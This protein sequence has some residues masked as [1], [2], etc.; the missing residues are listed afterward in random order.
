M[1]WGLS[2]MSLICPATV[3]LRFRR[4]TGMR[5]L[6]VEWT[7]ICSSVWIS[8]RAPWTFHS[9]GWAGWPCLVTRSLR[10]TCLPPTSRRKISTSRFPKVGMTFPWAS[11][12][13]RGPSSRSTW[14]PAES[15]PAGNI[16]ASA[17]ESRTIVVKL[18]GSLNSKLNCPQ[19][20]QPQ[21]GCRWPH[22]LLSLLC[23]I[24]LP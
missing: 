8:T 13:R 16:V 20:L 22:H 19:P 6:F 10:Q 12:R 5:V 23:S 15:Q 11:C 4:S 14:V 9:R 2:W 18:L 21:H 7:S 24:A 17:P 1:W 3:R